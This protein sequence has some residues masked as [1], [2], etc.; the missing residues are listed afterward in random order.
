[1]LKETVQAE[2]PRDWVCDLDINGFFDNIDHDLL[3]LGRRTFSH[4]ANRR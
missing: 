2:D 3:S 1:M 4:T